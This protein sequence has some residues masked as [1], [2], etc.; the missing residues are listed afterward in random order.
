MHRERRALMRRLFGVGGVEH[1]NRVLVLLGPADGT[2]QHRAQRSA[3]STPWREWADRHP[4]RSRSAYSRGGRVCG[5]PCLP[6]RRPA[7]GFQLGVGLGSQGL[8]WRPPALVQ[9]ARRAPAGR[10][11][12]RRGASTRRNSPWKRGRARWSD[13]LGVGSGVDP[14]YGGRIGDS[15]LDF[16]IPARGPSMS[17]FLHRGQGWCRGR[18]YRLSI[19][20]TGAHV[21]G[22]SSRLRRRHGLPSDS[23]SREPGA[24]RSWEELKAS[25]LCCDRRCKVPRVLRTRPRR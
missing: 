21:T 25:V 24:R 7:R 5:P 10:R 9:P 22:A 4:A 14:G 23:M 6:R 18:R 1:L 3:A 19:E 20:V 17:S 16:W 15:L 11:R 13:A 2:S 12:R 8:C